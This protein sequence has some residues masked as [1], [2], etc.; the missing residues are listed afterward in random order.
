MCL[1]S[2][3]RRDDL[4]NLS[5]GVLLFAEMLKAHLLSL[6]GGVICWYPVR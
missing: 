2:L 6:K 4:G 3:N 5:E 1:A